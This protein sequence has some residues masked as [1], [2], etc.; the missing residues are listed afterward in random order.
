MKNA[1]IP[2]ATIIGLQVGGLIGGSVSSESLAF[3][4]WTHLALWA[5]T[6]GLAGRYLGSAVRARGG[7][8]SMV[9]WLLYAAGAIAILAFAPAVGLEHWRTR[10]HR[11]ARRD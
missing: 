11:I 2:I 10:P 5:I 6:V 3:V 8:L 1:L 4:L 7:R 9:P